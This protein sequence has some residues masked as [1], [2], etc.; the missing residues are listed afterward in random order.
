MKDTVTGAARDTRNSQPVTL[1]G[2]EHGQDG[3][4]SITSV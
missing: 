4:V 3:I 1:K 2:A